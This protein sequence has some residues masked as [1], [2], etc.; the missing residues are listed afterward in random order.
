MPLVL[1]RTVAGTMLAA[2]LVATSLPAAT[3]APP[4]GGER[5]VVR[6]DPR[7][8]PSPFCGGYWV[9]LANR[10]RTR[11]HDGLLRP[12]CYVARAVDEDRHALAGALPD[13]ALVRAALEPWTFESFGELGVLVVADVRHPAGAAAA[14]RFFRVRD[15]GVRCVRAPCF[16]L[17]AAVLNAAERVSLSELDLRPARLDAAA[18]ERAEADLASRGGLYVAGRVVAGEQGGRALRA[19][20]LYLRAPPPRA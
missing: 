10:A 5:Y 8:C 3:A 16:S 15:T 13:G 1:L 6:P 7:L 11:C 12:R 9:A 14:G 4:V 17:R 20:R 18:R 19:S 2:A